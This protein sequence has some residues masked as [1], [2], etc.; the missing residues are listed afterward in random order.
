MGEGAP[1]VR[2][3]HLCTQFTTTSY[4]AEKPRPMDALVVVS[5]LGLHIIGCQENTCFGW[6]VVLVGNDCSVRLQEEKVPCH[7]LDELFHNILR[8]KLDKKL[9]LNS[10]ILGYILLRHFFAL[11]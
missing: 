11:L 10:A 4:L 7:I 1:I 3:E 2:C 5:K 6:A 9:Q 8:I